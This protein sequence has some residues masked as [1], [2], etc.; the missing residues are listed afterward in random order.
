MR[1]IHPLGVLPSG[2]ALVD[3]V[4]A[5]ER[6]ERRARGLGALAS[7]DDATL[8]GVLDVLTR[9]DDGAR[10]LARLAC[11]SRAMR[12]FATHED[13]WKA[14]TLER[15]GG[16]FTFG[17]RSWRE[18]Y[19][20]AAAGTREAGRKRRL[21]EDGEESVVR[22]EIY[23]DVLYQRYM[24]AEM[25]LE[26]EWTDASTSTVP[27]AEAAT[28]SLDEFRTKFESLNLP[29]VIRGGCK[30]WPA[31]KKWTRAWLSKT[32]GATDFVVGGYDM[33]LNDFF[34]VC[35]GAR[36]DVPLYLFDPKFGEKAPELA[37]DYEV[38][39]YFA[40]DDLFKL[41]HE[42]PH[43]RWLIIGP[44]KSGSIFHQ[45]PN[46][47]SAWNAVVSGRKKWVMFPPTVTP[48]GVHPSADGADVAQPLSIVEWF[49]NF[50]DADDS[51]RRL[52]CVCEPGDVLFVPSG[53]WHLALNLTE[54]IAVT[55]NFVSRANLR[56]VLAFLDSKCENL[57]SGVD[58]NRRRG[59]GDD[60][61]A[62]IRASEDA[63]LIAILDAH[64]R[65]KSSARKSSSAVADAFAAA[66]SN[67][68][69][70]A[71]AAS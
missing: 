25:E 27:E 44:A 64:E 35:D 51:K 18:T 57:V 68:F 60:F 29:V 34:A 58:K 54:C 10:A 52:E 2:N 26:P 56:K 48:P 53:W 65:A 37:S 55:Q 11:A 22:A 15:H 4:S 67:S 13:L 20:R 40:T 63:E 47:T 16:R 7:L 36:D 19:A 8:L 46:A 6:H 70:F 33:T 30:H 62:A 14:A 61:S 66:S 43:H 59:L 49:A 39:E 9:D 45:D 17:G 1:S 21:E 69:A 31:M 50:Y 32:Y 5:R 41:L 24:C 12:A 42:R 71:F 3:H 38:P 28:L 23:S